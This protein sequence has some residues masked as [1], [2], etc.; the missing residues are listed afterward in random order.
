MPKEGG[1]ARLVPA[2]GIVLLL[3]AAACNAPQAPAP[4]T[5]G[6]EAGKPK[7]GGVLN[8]RVPTDF[9]DFDV[10]YTGKGTNSRAQGLAH[11]S[12]LAFETGPGVGYA[13]YKLKPGL[14][15]SWQVS[16]DGT[17]LTYNLRKGLKFAD[18]PP[19]NGRALTAEDVK[20]TY[21]YG[22]RTGT[23][24]DKKLPTGQFDWMFE[25]LQE[26]TT[27]GPQT[28][29]VRFKEP[30]APFLNYSG[31]ILNPILAREIYDQDGHF[32]DRIVGAGPFQLD[33]AASQKGSRWVFKKNPNYW[34]PGKPYL[35]EVRWIVMP[36]DSTTAAA[37]QV[38]QVGL[39]GDFTHQPSQVIQKNNPKATMFDLGGAT[40][41]HMYM[42]MKFAP[43]QDIRVRKAIALGINRDEFTQEEIRKMMP[44]DPAQGKQLMVE[45]GYANGL[46]IQFEYPTDNGQVYI[47]DFQLLQSQLKKIGVNFVAKPMS[48]AEYSATKKNHTATVHTTSKDW[49][50]DIDGYLFGSFYSKSKDNYDRIDDPKLDQMLFA[51]RREADPAKRTELIKQAVRYINTEAYLGRALYSKG[52]Y[53]FAA[54][55]LKGFAPNFQSALSFTSA[56][57]EN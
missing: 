27:A 20:W 39:I 22:S 25:G 5:G 46:D 2:I 36:D 12:L 24:K 55:A 3:S 41:V 11:S 1:M 13:E 9:Y 50:A 10:S 42:N 4:S 16:P 45:A 37:F 38:G 34:E 6:D 53:M 21:E 40:P 56:W 17:T 54:P 30:F 8:A 19:V 57:L 7:Y 31:H 32:K 35:D 15:E 33:V 14:A 43:F 23:V 28:V 48:Y 52:T 44:Y 47:V 51:Q 26:I 29:T 18:L 49:Q